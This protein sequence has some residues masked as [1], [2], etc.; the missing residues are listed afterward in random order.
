MRRPSFR[1]SR[2]VALNSMGRT[3]RT[4]CS[5]GLWVGIRRCRIRRPPVW[6]PLAIVLAWLVGS[7]LL[8]WAHSDLPSTL[9]SDQP[10][11]YACQAP[12]S[13][14]SLV[15][16]TSPTLP[17]A[18]LTLILFM[19]IAVAMAQRLWRWRKTTALCLVLVLGTF[20]F[21]IA[22]HSVHH[23]LEPKS[24]A[25][26]LMFSAS[27]HVSGSLAEPCDTHAPVLAVTTPSPGTSDGSTI[28]L[29]CRAD[30]PRAPPLFL[31]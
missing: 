12:H 17:G 16:P 24:A 7:P 28:S 31:A 4:T 10:L 9:S 22:I 14:F 2:G 5:G 21:G 23:L 25:H 26:C 18:L 29:S 8:I 27:Q 15:Q 20:T 30:L 1:T 19:L 11:H 3:A 13:W 6:V